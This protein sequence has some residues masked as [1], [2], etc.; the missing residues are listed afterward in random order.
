MVKIWISNKSIFLGMWTIIVC[1]IYM[2]MGSAPVCSAKT[3][4]F[5]VF[6]NNLAAHFDAKKKKKNLKSWRMPF[7]NNLFQVLFTTTY[8]KSKIKYAIV[9]IYSDYDV[10]ASP[11]PLRVTILPWYPP[12]D[13]LWTGIH[14]NKVISSRK[15]T[16]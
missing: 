1:K 15:K 7:S 6:L 11:T 5:P 12:K 14:L 16:I 9:Y 13:F 8:S 3:S 4:L 2:C 10:L